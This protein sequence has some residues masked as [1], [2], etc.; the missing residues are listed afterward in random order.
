MIGHLD[1]LALTC[2]DEAATVRFYVDLL[3][4]RLETF[5]AGR[6]AFRFSN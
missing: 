4:M 3:G 2:T 6:K 1:H 5:G